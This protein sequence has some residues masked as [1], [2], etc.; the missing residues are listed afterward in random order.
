[1]ADVGW[2]PIVACPWSVSGSWGGLVRVAS[3]GGLLSA[4]GA[5]VLQ[6]LSPACPPPRSRPQ[7]KR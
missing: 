2:A 4:P 1:M 3:L 5:L 7:V 6:W